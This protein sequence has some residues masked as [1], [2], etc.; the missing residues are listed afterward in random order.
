[1]VV[2]LNRFCLKKVKKFLNVPDT[3]SVIFTRS[4]TESLNLVAYAWGQKFLNSDSEILLSEMEHHSNLVPW[5]L[6]AQKTKTS[7]KF[8]LPK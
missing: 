7:L 2:V 4:T 1:M 5:Q 8:M 6:V 3:H